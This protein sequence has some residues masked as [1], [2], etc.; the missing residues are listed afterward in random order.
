MFLFSQS[1]C[2][3]SIRF[4]AISNDK[5]NVKDD[6]MDLFLT[7]MRNMFV[8]KSVWYLFVDFLDIKLVLIKSRYIQM[9]YTSISHATKKESNRKI[10]CCR[11]LE[12]K[13]KL[14]SVSKYGDA[15]KRSYN[16]EPIVRTHLFNIGNSYL[17]IISK[18]H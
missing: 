8:Y 13:L 16:Y 17:R 7:G 10:R 12:S 14:N 5:N 18:S 6:K 1:F 15:E 11:A 9:C 2:R 3:Y 4:C